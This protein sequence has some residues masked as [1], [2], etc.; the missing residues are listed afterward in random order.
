[1]FRTNL[2]QNIYINLKLRDHGEK[3]LLDFAEWF[4]GSYE[5]GFD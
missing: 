2:E 3:K 4:S 1:M 5:N